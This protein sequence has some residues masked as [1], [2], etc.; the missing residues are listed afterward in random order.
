MTRRRTVSLPCEEPNFVLLA[1]HAPTGVIYEQQCG[2]S[3]CDH[4]EIEGYLTLLVRQ[5]PDDTT[6]DR[7]GVSPA[8]LTAI[9]HNEDDHCHFSQPWLITPERVER[10]SALI[11]TLGYFGGPDGAPVQGFELDRSRIG[12]VYEAWVPVTT[13]DGTGVLL[14]NN[15]D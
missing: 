9:F 7:F 15:C 4:R 3:Y 2:G 8:D 10:L 5:E 14:W 6:A 12:E 11:L 13:A 1:I